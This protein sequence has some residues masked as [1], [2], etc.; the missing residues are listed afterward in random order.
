MVLKPHT[1]HPSLRRH[2]NILKR[3]LLLY[4]GALNLWLWMRTLLGVGTQRGLQGR[5]AA[6]L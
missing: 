6:F 1:V 5:V 4:V 2:H 3:I